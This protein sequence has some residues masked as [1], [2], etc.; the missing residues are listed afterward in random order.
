MEDLESTEGLDW[1]HIAT[2]VAIFELSRI[3][4]LF[5]LI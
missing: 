1:E 4:F 5:I 2:K 3:G